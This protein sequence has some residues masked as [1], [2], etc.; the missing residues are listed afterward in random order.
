MAGLT[1][2]AQGLFL[3]IP[4]QAPG[5]DWTVEKLI[6]RPISDVAAVDIDGDGELELATIEPF[7]GNEFVINKK[8]ED[9]YQIVYRY[10]NIM[11]FGHVVWGGELCGV[12][13][14]IGGNRRRNK[15]LFLVRGV[16][17]E[18]PCFETIVIDAGQGPSNVAVLHEDGKDV[19]LADNREIAQAAYYTVTK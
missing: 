14:F 10:P 11:D 19:I 9:G 3:V 5:K 7:H 12:P 15:E 4:P 2:C 17:A 16:K 8:S 6:D 13:C 18:E 1:T